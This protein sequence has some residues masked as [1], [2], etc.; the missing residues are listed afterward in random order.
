MFLLLHHMSKRLQIS[1]KRHRD[2]TRRIGEKVKQISN[3]VITG[4]V[5][6]MYVCVCGG[7]GGVKGNGW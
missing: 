5:V 7:G 4:F 1:E 3:K 2:N 6:C